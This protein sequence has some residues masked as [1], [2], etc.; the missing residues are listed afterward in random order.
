METV[1]SYGWLSARRLDADV[2]V[3]TKASPGVARDIEFVEACLVKGH[4]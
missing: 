4:S 1:L 3:L 2:E